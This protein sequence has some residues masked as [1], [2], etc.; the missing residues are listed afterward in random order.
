MVRVACRYAEA[1]QPAFDLKLPFLEGTAGRGAKHL[2]LRR[3]FQRG[4]RDR[5][6]FVVV[7]LLQIG[8]HA[9]HNP[10]EKHFGVLGRLGGFRDGLAHRLAGKRQRGGANLL[11][12]PGKMEIER[13]TRGAASG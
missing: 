5:T 1:E 6:T 4:G 9:A 2:G 8:G 7:G 10:R 11:F 13:A 12:A 3:G